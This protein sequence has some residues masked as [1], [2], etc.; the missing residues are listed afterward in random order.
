MQ[1]AYPNMWLCMFESKFYT[2][3]SCALTGWWWGVSYTTCRVSCCRDMSDSA[4]FSAA[5]FIFFISCK[6]GLI[7]C[8]WICSCVQGS[9][10]VSLPRPTSLVLPFFLPISFNP[11]VSFSA[12]CLQ[13]FSVSL[14][15]SYLL[16]HRDENV[17]TWV[18]VHVYGHGF[19][20]KW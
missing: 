15:H 4:A 19:I 13:L 11:K 20:Q 10:V 17:F 2:I 1:C 3:E 8:C 6:L 7:N 5:V 12:W 9:K 14:S 18:T 16:S